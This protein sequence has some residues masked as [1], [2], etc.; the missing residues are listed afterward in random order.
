MQLENLER[1]LSAKRLDTYYR[2]FNGEKNDAIEYYQLNIKISEA[3]YPLLANLEIVL[4]NSIHQS[5]TK[6]F[7]TENW[8]ETLE[9]QDLIDQIKI[10]NSKIIKNR[11]VPNCDKIVAEL[12]FGFWT[13]LFNKQYARL[14]WRP[15]MFSFKELDD[16]NKH[17]DKIAYSLNQV[18]KFR[19][20]VFHYEPICNDLSALKINYNNM[21]DVLNWLDKDLVTWTLSNQDFDYLY[22]KA[23]E[24]RKI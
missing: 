10:A 13:S 20:R 23:I 24:L 12:T 17:R 22:N 6:R 4:R 1:L 16:K 3:L 19:N 15:L 18:R 14:L 21:I 9:Y 8:F 5:F 11:Q 2:L 7:G